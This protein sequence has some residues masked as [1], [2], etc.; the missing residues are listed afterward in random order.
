MDILP[1]NRTTTLLEG[2]EKNVSSIEQPHRKG[3]D[4]GWMKQSQDFL[5]PLRSK[6]NF[7]VHNIYLT[8]IM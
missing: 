8:Y 1:Q 3:S 5:E 2:L 6:L 7:D 4:V